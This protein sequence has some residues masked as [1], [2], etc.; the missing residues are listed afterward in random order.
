MQ[1]LI[2]AGRIESTSSR[3]G[4]VRYLDDFPGIRLNNVWTDAVGSFMA[5]KSYV[6]QT[7]TK[8]IQRCILM[9]TDPGDLVFDPTCGSGT[10]GYVA[11]QWG[12]RWITTDVSRVPLALARQRL[13]TATY[14]YYQ[15]KD[16]QRGPA[17]GFVYARK[18]NKKGE[19]VGGIVPHITLRSIA[20]NEPAKEEVLVDKPETVAN[21]TRISGPFC[22]EAVL[23]TPLSPEIEKADQDTINEPSAPEENLSA[24]NEDNHIPRMIRILQLS[25]VLHLQDNNK[26]N[27]NNIRPPAKSLNIH[28]EGS[29]VDEKH[30]D[31]SEPIAI[32]FGP[33][34]GA[35]SE[36]AVIEAGKEAHHKN[37]ALL[38][39]IAFAIEPAARQTIERGEATFK[40]ACDLRP[41][42]HR[43][44]YVRPA[45]KYALQPDFFSSWPARRGIKKINR[46]SRRRWRPMASYP[47][48]SRHLR[49]RHH[50]NRI[51][52]R[53]RRPLLDAGHQLRWPMLP[54]RS[55]ILPTHR[56]LG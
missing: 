47:T 10:T 14:P 26:F 39:V 18:Q 48:R 44:G 19:E 50:A 7:N 13:L 21:T 3:I 52:Q 22:V 33:A 4:Y 49:P 12:R 55:S 15:L 17:G 38:L 36:R 23:P 35:I 5:G 29:R 27:L 46:K 28:A 56:S 20:N 6:V 9:T 53:R 40:P 42:Q 31:R 1:C 8:V 34:N 41:G 16:Q 11:E 43:P 51:P 30:P 25:P 24:D 37:Y 32:V 54:R 2:A 45:Q